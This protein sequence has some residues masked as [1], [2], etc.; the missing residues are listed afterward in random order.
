MMTTGNQGELRARD[1]IDASD[2]LFRYVSNGRWPELRTGGEKN[3]KP[4]LNQR[5][6]SGK[7]K[8][9]VG[10]SKMPFAFG[11]LTVMPFAFR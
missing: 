1:M 9:M 5:M 6:T 7:K 4:R 11:R 8:K 3:V 2:T 10:L